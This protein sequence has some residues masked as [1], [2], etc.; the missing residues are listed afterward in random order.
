M[1]SLFKINNIIFDYRHNLKENDYLLLNNYM[2]EIKLQLNKE[3]FRTT[4]MSAS[5]DLMNRINFEEY[6]NDYI[7]NFELNFDD[8]KEHIIKSHNLK[9]HVLK[10]KHLTRKLK[11]NSIWYRIIDN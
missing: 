3:I 4:I 10:I 9:E 8:E 1:D 7:N 11:R 2:M 6:T 5:D